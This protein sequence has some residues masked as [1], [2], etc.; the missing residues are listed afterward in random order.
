MK[1]AIIISTIIVVLV[2]GI[3]IFVFG[4]SSEPYS[5]HVDYF[6]GGKYIEEELTTDVFGKTLTLNVDPNTGISISLCA[7]QDKN[8]FLT[9]KHFVK[10]GVDWDG[11]NCSNTHLYLAAGQQAC[12]TLNIGTVEEPKWVSFKIETIVNGRTSKTVDTAKNIPVKEAYSEP[13]STPVP[14]N[15]EEEYEDYDILPEDP[16]RVPESIF[17]TQRTSDW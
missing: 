14:C 9:E 6:N 4:K 13:V 1:K 15:P 11:Y 12:A 17:A 3:Y 10:E 7:N 2:T 8:F 16:G 5:F